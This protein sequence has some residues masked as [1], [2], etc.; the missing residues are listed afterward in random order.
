[1]KPMHNPVH[2][3]ATLIALQKSEPFV[4][5]KFTSD[6]EFEGEGL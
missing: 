1:M 2:C 3:N 4:H 5:K 6:E